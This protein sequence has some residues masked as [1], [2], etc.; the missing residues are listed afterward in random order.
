M[1]GPHE[2]PTNLENKSAKH[3]IE[4]ARA[5]TLV[6]KHGGILA[7][8]REKALPVTAAIAVLV[9]RVPEQG[10]AGDC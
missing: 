8:C 6:H 2:E 3:A 7:R 4:P 10:V 1:A 9:P 5:G